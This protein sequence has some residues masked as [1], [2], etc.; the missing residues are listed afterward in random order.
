[1]GAHIWL[2]LSELDNSYALWCCESFLFWVLSLPKVIPETESNYLVTEKW[3]GTLSWI[4][5]ALT[6]G[7]LLN[8]CPQPLF[9]YCVSAITSH[10]KFCWNEQRVFPTQPQCCLNFS[11]IE[12][13]MLLRC[14]LIYITIIIQ[15]HILYLVYLCPFLG[16]GLFMLYL[17]DLFFIFS[18]IFIA[19]N[20]KTSFKQ[21]YLFFV[22]LG[23]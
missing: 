21:M 16:L 22:I 18:L 7:F 23:W 3:S 10:P 4:V 19:I 11:W 15:R 17:Y 13:H 20:H 8:L 12:L 2:G 14:C 5:K 9:C 1:M 6:E